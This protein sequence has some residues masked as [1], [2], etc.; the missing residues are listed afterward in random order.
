[1]AELGAA[2][3]LLGV[4]TRTF[5]REDRMKTRPSRLVAVVVPLSSRPELSPEEEVSMRHVSHFLGQYDKF[6]V[7]PTG[8]PMRRNG[9][10]TLYFPRKFFGSAAAHNRLLMWPRFYRIFED[11]EYIL[12]YHLDSLV[13]SDRLG[14]WC[15][16]G[17]DYIGAPWLPCDD[18]PWVKEPRVGNGGFTLMKVESV[19]Q[20]L[21]N[22][23][24]QKPITYWADLLTRNG[25]FF[26]PVFMALERFQQSYPR[27]RSLER[28]LQYWRKSEHPVGANNDYFWSYCA[29][30]YHDGFK[31]APFQEGL[32]FAF[33]AAP[34]QCFELNRGELP[35]GCHAWS[36]FDRAFWEPYLLPQP[37]PDRETR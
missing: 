28:V 34:R 35:F 10:T 23:Y 16:E 19:L 37:A 8:V 36:K 24:R 18:T 12:V 27:S 4:V 3:R 25:H 5:L 29:A 14:H 26:R 1:M 2:M 13:F 6:L 22:R 20:V 33:E 11:Y 17:W 32:R 31:V 9:F 15:A 21:S 7:A 30:D